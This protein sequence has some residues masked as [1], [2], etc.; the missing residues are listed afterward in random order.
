MFVVQRHQVCGHLLQQP[1]S[2]WPCT[3]TLAPALHLS[4]WLSTDSEASAW[5]RIPD[6]A[7][8]SLSNSGCTFSRIV[9][10]KVILPEFLDYSNSFPPNEVQ[11][12]FDK[13]THFRLPP[14]WLWVPTDGLSLLIHWPSK[15]GWVVVE[16]P[17]REEIS[18]VMHVIS[19]ICISSTE[20]FFQYNFVHKSKWFFTCFCNTKHLFCFGVISYSR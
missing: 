15:N 2:C 4:A 20:T 5:V 12:P 8:S 18:Y 13:N 14:C 6:C 1:P 9:K 17:A 10:E 11:Y 16:S 3:C 7:L 19:N